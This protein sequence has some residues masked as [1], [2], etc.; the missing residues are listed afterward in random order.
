MTCIS[1]N[2]KCK[3]RQDGWGRDKKALGWVGEEVRTEVSLY[4]CALCRMFGMT[5]RIT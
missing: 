4:R 2:V 1:H 3:N 5:T